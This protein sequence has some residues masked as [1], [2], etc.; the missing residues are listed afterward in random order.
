LSHPLE[1]AKALAETLE[2]FRGGRIV[3]NVIEM[4]IKCPMGPLEFTFLDDAG[5]A[6]R[7]EPWRPNPEATRSDESQ[8][9]RTATKS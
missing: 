5:A 2:G 6:A 4:P 1:G 8:K 3:V 9:R 7:W